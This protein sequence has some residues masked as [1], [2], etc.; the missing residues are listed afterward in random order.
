VHGER[1]KTVDPGTVISFGTA[2][3]VFAP[4]LW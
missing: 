4:T 1:R 3:L 2:D